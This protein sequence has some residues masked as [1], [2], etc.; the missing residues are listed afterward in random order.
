[1]AGMGWLRTFWDMIRPRLGE[2]RTAFGRMS[3]VAAISFFLTVLLFIIG[4]ILTLLGVDLGGVDLWLEGHGEGID[5]LATLAFRLVAGL[6]LLIC[7]LMI[8]SGLFGKR[9]G[10]GQG[11]D[12]SGGDKP[13]VGCMVLLAIIGYFAWIGMTG[14]L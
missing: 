12:K 14:D 8:G 11:G 7:V 5:G 1:M 3:A 10:D 6:V 2:R 4:F 9:G 13:G